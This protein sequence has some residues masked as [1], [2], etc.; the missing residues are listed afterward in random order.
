MK[1]PYIFTRDKCYAYKDFSK[2]LYFQT[3]METAHISP[4]YKYVLLI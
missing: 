1:I 3:K 2:N 4:N